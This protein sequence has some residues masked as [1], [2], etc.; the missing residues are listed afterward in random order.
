MSVVPLLWY[1]SCFQILCLV[2]ERD[3]FFVHI[4]LLCGNNHCSCKQNGSDVYIS[5][6]ESQ[7]FSV[8]NLQPRKQARQTNVLLTE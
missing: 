8:F 7:D 5:P 4:F 1:V 2:L 3:I 6:I